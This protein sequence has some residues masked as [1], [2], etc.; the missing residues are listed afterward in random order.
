MHKPNRRGSPVMVL[1]WCL[2]SS[3]MIMTSNGYIK[4][5]PVSD[6]EA[7][8]RGTRYTH[9]HTHTTTTHTQAIVPRR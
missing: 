5:M 2:C 9:T 6:F 1:L 8:G 7:Q 3:V 4:R